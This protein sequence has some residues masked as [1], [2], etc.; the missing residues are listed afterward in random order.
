MTTNAEPSEYSDTALAPAGESIGAR[1][2]LAYRGS[3]IIQPAVRL[4]RLSSIEI[5]SVAIG[6]GLIFLSFTL[7][8]PPPP[9]PVFPGGAVVAIRLCAAGA[10]A[11]GLIPTLIWSIR[12]PVCHPDNFRF[13]Q[14]VRRQPGSDK[15]I[16]LVGNE[17]QLKRA[18]SHGPIEDRSFEPIVIRDWT[19]SPGAG[20]VV[21]TMATVMLVLSMMLM[22]PAS[23]ANGHLHIVV[24]V[25]LSIFVWMLAIPLL[26]P[27]YIRITPGLFETIRLSYLPWRKPKVVRCSLRAERVE[28]DL[29]QN[30][31]WSMN[32]SGVRT[33]IGLTNLRMRDR[34]AYHVLLAAVSTATV[35][36]L[37][38]DALIG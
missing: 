30:A 35:P 26:S 31:I 19:P 28:I 4:R 34:L 14:D 27:R 1:V 6:V 16:W 7:A 32:S 13:L 10:I 20:V 11:C 36:D 22:R 9:R 21:M 15:P 5:V 12:V 3:E 17:D 37:P 24:G 18:L 25:H 23:A 29:R 8:L 33:T 2:G 38:E